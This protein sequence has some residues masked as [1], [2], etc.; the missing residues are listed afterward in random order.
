MPRPCTDRNLLVGVVALQRDLISRD[1]LID[2]M[3]EWAKNQARSLGQIL[4]DRAS[5]DQDTLVLL[6]TLVDRELEQLDSERISQVATSLAAPGETVDS[7]LRNGSAA[8]L[9]CAD[10]VVDERS[11]VWDAGLRTRYRVLWPHARGGLGQIHVAED[12]EL[13]RHVALK[14]IQPK[15][16]HNPI[17]RGRFLFEAEI[18]ANLEHPGIVPVHG[19][20]TY[21]DGRP[22]YTMRLIRGEQLMTAIRRFHAAEFPDFAGLEFRWL[23]QRFYDVCNTIAYA[24]S[25]GILH[26]DLKPGNI[27][28]GPFGE[29]LVMDWGL[30]KPLGQSEIGAGAAVE[31][32]PTN[33]QPEPGS[34]LVTCPSQAVGTPVYMSPEQAAGTLDALGP[35]S[36]VY[37]LGATLYVL[38]TGQ[39]PFQGADG[40]V[41]QAVRH[42][43]FLGPRQVNPRVPQALDS[44]CRQAM[45][46]QPTQRYQSALAL[47]EDI[48]RWLADEPVSAWRE[49]WPDR[50]RR[51]IRRHQP[52]VVGWAAAI[53]VA[54][55]ALGV[56]V[57]LLSLA[58]R[59]ESSA[60]WN[61]RE[62]HLMALQRAKDA[63][64]Q[65][66][67]AQAHATHAIEERER[68]ERALKF[69]VA[70]F[71][72]PDPAADGRTLK[73]VDLLEWAANDLEKSMGDQPLMKATLLSAI[74]ETFAGLGL[75]PQSL[76][77]FERAYLIRRDQL[78]E[79]HLDTLESMDNLA[80][81]YQDA[82]RLDKAI[83][84]LQVALAKRREKLGDEHADT[85][86][87][88]NDLAV[89]YWE[90][91][92]VTRAIP[93]YE[94]TLS[95]VRHSLGE[96]H[97]DTLTIMDNLAVA[98]AAAGR[99][100]LAIPLH[101]TTLAMMRTKLGEDHPTT[102][103]TM[104]NLA[105]TLETGGRIVEAITIHE[106]TL[107]K[108]R[109]KL[110]DDHPTT[111]VSM[112]SLARAYQETG[113]RSRAIAL[114]EATL[115]KRRIKLGADHPD[116]LL[117]VVALANAYEDGKQPDKAIPL[118]R[119]FLDR[120]QKINQRLP[121]KVRAAI[122]RAAQIV[123]AVAKPAE[124]TVPE[125][126][127][128]KVP[129]RGPMP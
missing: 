55:L 15:H 1:E 116:T 4:L 7:E 44:I 76:S 82:G 105:R 98:Y 106:R 118:A 33:V 18:T 13:H 89:A 70:A 96:D 72:K 80:M 11:Q 35:A 119:E 21:P 83:P 61:E 56:A 99:P 129:D 27:M 95:I 34:P 73:V 17:S 77:V 60:R 41:L 31:A 16:A 127:L 57:P 5:L 50:G 112:N 8:G 19:L 79:D 65:R 53:G 45:A 111:L 128:R 110:G 90:E 115:V 48:E 81:A 114:F 10:L 24:H 74:G 71:R 9:S 125:E 36:D 93:L 102:L 104:N 124:P 6:D 122:P 84:I 54:F 22:F 126:L 39:R 88:M 47:G 66:A 91:G 120:T 46:V 63:Q 94:T 29:T 64:E 78:G 59:N 38:L 123:V 67:S 51:W 113:Q 52:L 75:P 3:H 42:G 25:R 97:S 20:G 14:E 109:A 40:D 2:A 85:L 58:W 101:E 107:E 26:R 117:T 49:P 12:T 108:L 43:R 62:Q 87:S 30:A 121:A 100:D 32:S 68:A 86:E 37:S 28:L 92:Q 23:L 103:I 69:L